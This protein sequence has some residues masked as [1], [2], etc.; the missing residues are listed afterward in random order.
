MFRTIFIAL[1]IL[2]VLAISPYLAQNH[3]TV[4]LVFNDTSYQTPLFN[5]IFGFIIFLA[6]LYI[7]EFLVRGI[8]RILFGWIINRRKRLQAKSA[9]QAEMGL[10]ELVAGNYQKAQVLLRR[11]AKHAK[12]PVL[13]LT[14][15]FEVA[16]RNKD[17]LLA[18]TS[19]KE[20]IKIAADKD[21]DIID[22][23]KL[24]YFSAKQEWSK[25]KELLLPVK[26][27]VDSE[28]VN[29]LAI[30][31]YLNTQSYGKLEDLLP[32]LVERKF[33][34]QAQYLEYY[35]LAEAGFMDIQLKDGVPAL[36]AW[37]ENQTRKRRFNIYTRNVLLQKLL[38][39]KE[40]DYAIKIATTTF[41][42]CNVK[43]IEATDFID[44]VTTIKVDTIDKQLSKTIEKYYTKFS[45]ANQYRLI[46][47]LSHLFYQ[48]AD[49]QS[50]LKWSEKQLALE[51]SNN[52]THSTDN[53]LLAQVLYRK[54]GEESKLDKIAQTIDG[55][56]HLTYANDEQEAEKA[57]DKDA[58]TEAKANEKTSK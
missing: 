44:M 51:T 33:I 39:L 36:M 41:K 1:L 55:Q 42:V 25:A 45:L 57:T 11:S 13:N 56:L 14:Q 47:L 49:Y 53:M 50:S 22:V 43:D 4:T 19:L 12:D 24:K 34:D 18:D 21:Q 8:V 48:A 15:T 54:L 52:Q 38:E 20:A 27:R 40:D 10:R 58:S 9:R 7:L 6:A 29:L 17:M 23:C 16:L 37:W 28:E 35:K 31:I 32:E 30:Q 5:F 2:V 3:G 26:D 46:T